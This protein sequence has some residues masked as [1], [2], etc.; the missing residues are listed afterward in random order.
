MNIAAAANVIGT[1]GD[2]AVDL[3]KILYQASRAPYDSRVSI[4][5]KAFK[6][7]YG[8][9]YFELPFRN[10]DLYKTQEDVLNAIATGKYLTSMAL[11]F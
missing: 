2:E 8:Q 3:A 10:A 5:D 9:S 4:G 6:N 1:K 11:M 7:L